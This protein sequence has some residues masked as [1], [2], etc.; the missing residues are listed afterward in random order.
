MGNIVAMVFFLIMY[1][2]SFFINS[3]EIPTSDRAAASLSSHTGLS[4]ALDVFLLVEGEVLFL[5]YSNYL[6]FKRMRELHFQI[7]VC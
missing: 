1:I 6:L 5:N 4:F 7:L 3:G 2:S